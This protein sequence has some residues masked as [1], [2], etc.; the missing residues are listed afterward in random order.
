MKARLP[1]TV[2]IAGRRIAIKTCQH[3]EDLGQYRHESKEILISS[4]LSSRMMVETLRHE[5]IHASLA[6][7]GISFAEKYDEEPIVRAIEQIFFPSWEN[8]QKQMQP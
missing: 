4:K 2:S 3:L 6:M 8:A 7:A 5:M 1:Q